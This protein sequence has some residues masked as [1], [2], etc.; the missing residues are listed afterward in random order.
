MISV[1]LRLESSAANLADTIQQG[2]LPAKA[3]SL[4]PSIIEVCLCVETFEPV[5][6]CQ[7]NALCVILNNADGK[8]VYSKG[9]GSARARWERDH[10]TAY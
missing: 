5:P 4:A 3:S 2:S 6:S 7:A 1:P 9:Y 10:G 8:V